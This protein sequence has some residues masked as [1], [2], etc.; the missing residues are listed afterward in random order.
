MAFSFFGL[1]FSPL[2]VC[3]AICFGH[4][5]GERDAGSLV[6]HTRFLVFD[7][8]SLNLNPI[9]LIPSTSLNSPYVPSLGP[10]VHC[11]TVS[12]ACVHFR[13]IPSANSVITM[14]IFSGLCL[15]PIHHFFI[16]TL[17]TGTASIT[18]YQV[19]RSLP[20]TAPQF[21]SLSVFLKYFC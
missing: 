14:Q 20:R 12:L 7:L 10:S 19:S 6:V 13:F 3:W 15:D 21:L 11:I 5:H 8:R 4:L 18:F 16:L 1:I 9:T 2:H 17:L